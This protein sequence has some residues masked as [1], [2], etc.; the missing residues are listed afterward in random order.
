MKYA[1]KVISVNDNNLY[2]I[3]V[4]SICGGII[5]T[6]SE[7]FTCKCGNVYV[8]LVEVNK[9]FN[10]WCPACNAFENTIMYFHIER[11]RLLDQA[12]NTEKE[13]SSIKEPIYN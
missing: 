12:E 1:D 4:R 7:V 5:Y 6:L 2:D 11:F 13:N 10:M 8:R 9:N 3:P